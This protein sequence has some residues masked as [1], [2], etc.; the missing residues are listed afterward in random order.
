MANR[1]VRAR[2]Q[3]L[4]DW[5][6]SSMGKKERKKEEYRGCSV[7]DLS[8]SVYLSMMKSDDLVV[9]EWIGSFGADQSDGE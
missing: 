5:S 8:R 7:P 2:R 9:G 6:V 1:D 3:F 4:T